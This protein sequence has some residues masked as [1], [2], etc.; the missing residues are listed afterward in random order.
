M[1]EAYK[2]Q[3]FSHSAATHLP[4]AAAGLASRGYGRAQ[5]SP[6]ETLL[7]SFTIGIDQ[8][9]SAIFLLDLQG[10]VLHLNPA[11][12][13]LVR[14][15]RIL[16]TGTGRLAT[17]RRHETLEL[18]EA[19]AA[20][21][22]EVAPSAR[23]RVIGLRDRAG[24]VVMVLSAR[25]VSLTQN[26]RVIC[27]KAAD[28]NHRP[29][30]NGIRLAEIFSLTKTEAIVAERILQGAQTGDLASEFSVSPETVRS[31]VKA[32]LHKFNVANQA[33][34]VSCAMHALTAVG[35]FGAGDSVWQN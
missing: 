12:E 6:S 29:K 15:G 21:A 14:S 26:V 17:K 28:L 10:D 16:S 20:I 24:Y 7:K 22:G 34:M 35:G 33:Q 5:A 19:V 32:I 23:P 18:E 8:S 9:P 13:D 2:S 31:H 11:A 25:A 30:P 4:R 3:Q 1:S 27:V